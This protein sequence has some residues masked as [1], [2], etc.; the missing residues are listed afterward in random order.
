M[1]NM[2]FMFTK[3]QIYAR[4]KTVTRRLG[5]DFLK[6]GDLVMACEKCQ[7]LKKGEKITK[8]T[9]NRNTHVDK[10]PLY[11]IDQLDCIREGFRDKS[12]WEFVEMFCKEMGVTP[13][14]PVNRI[15]FE[16]VDE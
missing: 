5:W 6:P 15:A 10:I 14:T 8:I 16:Y 1:R 11:D 3:E 2:S 7:G 12:P 9:T 13:T 4:T